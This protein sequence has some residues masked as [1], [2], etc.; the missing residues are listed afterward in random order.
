MRPMAG[1]PVLP[2]D[3]TAKLATGDRACQV[4]EKYVKM[5]KAKVQP[6]HSRL[7]LY[8]PGLRR[9]IFHNST[10]LLACLD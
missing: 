10:L 6:S 3:C 5:A 8:T 2:S 1:F 9:N 4:R 7:W